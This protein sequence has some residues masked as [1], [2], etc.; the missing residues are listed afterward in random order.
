MDSGPLQAFR[1][2]S[3]AELRALRSRGGFDLAMKGLLVLTFG[4]DNPAA[5]TLH[6][7]DEGK[8]L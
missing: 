1:Y 3:Q 4:L 7:S 2:S 6:L 8:R 5:D